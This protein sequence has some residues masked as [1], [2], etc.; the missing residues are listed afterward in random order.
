VPESSLLGVDLND[1]ASLNTLIEANAMIRCAKHNQYT[2]IYV[3]A[4]P[5]HQLRAF[6]TS[7]TAAQ[8]FYPEINI[9][10]HNG[11]PLP[12]QDRVAHSQGET[13]GLRRDL[14][15]GEFDRIRKYQQKGDLA[16]DTDVLCYLNKR[17]D[18]TLSFQ[19]FTY[20]NT[21]LSKE[22]L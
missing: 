20:L 9:Y 18:R 11:H 14:I 21:A 8:K 4:S 2:D 1:T 3:I 19:R 5:F 7:V 17:D 6:M 22:A 16:S 10:S 13:S 15:G 12:W